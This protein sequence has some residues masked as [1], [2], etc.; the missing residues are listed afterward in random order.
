MRTQPK[1]WLFY[2]L[3]VLQHNVFLNFFFNARYGIFIKSVC[4]VNKL[5]KCFFC[6]FFF[7]TQRTRALFIAMWKGLQLAH[8]LKSYVFFSTNNFINLQNSTFW[9]ILYD[10]YWLNFLLMFCINTYMCEPKMHTMAFTNEISITNLGFLYKI[11]ISNIHGNGH[12]T[13]IHF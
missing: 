10:K 3:W 6:K 9:F 1:T 5:E 13:H 7:Q 11:I 8:V 12:V 2:K 4:E